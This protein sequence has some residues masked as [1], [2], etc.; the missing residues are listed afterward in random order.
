MAAP[1]K[2]SP[3]PTNSATLTKTHFLIYNQL[4]FVGSIRFLKSR[5][6]SK[7]SKE[8]STIYL[9]GKVIF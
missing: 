4:N 3:L 7:L 9:G 1:L 8:N 2:A 5:K 6:I